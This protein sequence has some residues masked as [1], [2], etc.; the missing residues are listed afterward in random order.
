MTDLG[1]VIRQYPIRN[2]AWNATGGCFYAEDSDL[3]TILD[4]WNR[5][6]PHAPEKQY[7][8]DG[9]LAFWNYTTTVAGQPVV[10]K[11]FNDWDL[12]YL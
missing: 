11:I 6:F 8:R 1:E 12:T 10:C 5:K 2:L 3:Q 7:N 4:P 9:D